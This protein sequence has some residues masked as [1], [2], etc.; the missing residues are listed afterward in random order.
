VHMSG[1]I[2]NHHPHIHIL[3]IDVHMHTFGG[4]LKEGTLVHTTLEI[5]LMDVSKAYQNK[6][7]Y[8]PDTG[9]DELEI[10]TTQYK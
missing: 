4:H 2:T 1:T 7:V 8:D 6:R 3:G 10:Q 9:Y 5:A